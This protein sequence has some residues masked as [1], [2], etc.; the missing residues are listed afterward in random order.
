VANAFAKI[1]L[2]GA[3]NLALIPA[4]GA[5]GAAAA[6]IGTR[7]FGGLLTLWYIRRVLRQRARTR[8]PVPPG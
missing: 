6:T 4:Y 7:V 8:S 2:N 3:A 1:A 5:F